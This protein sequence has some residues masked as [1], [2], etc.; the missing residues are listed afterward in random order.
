MKEPFRI[1]LILTGGQG[2]IGGME[3]IKNIIL[4]LASL[5]TEVRA[6]FEISLVTNSLTDSNFIEPFK[7]FV[8]KVHNI[9]TQNKPTLFKRIKRVI[10]T[11]FFKRPDYSVFDKFLR[12]NKFDF[13]YPYHS[14][15]CWKSL[16]NVAPWIPDFQ[17]K[18]L[19]QFFSEQ[20]I[21]DRDTMFADMAKHA[22]LVVISSRSAEADFK[23]FYPEAANKAKVLSFRTVSQ[24]GWYEE[25]PEALQQKYSLPDKFF[26]LC[27]QFWQHKNHLTV[28]RAMQ[29]LLEK[30]VKP[31]VVCTGH[32]YDY[33]Q[34]NYSDTIL[35]TIHMSGLAG[36]I[37]LLGLIPKSD[38][39]Q[40]L[41]RSI[42]L[43]QP[44]LFEGWSTVI[45]EARCMGK[46]MI[47]SDFS[48][49]LEQN[50]PNSRF[51]ERL[52]PES[53]AAIMADCWQKLS[54]GPVRELESKARETNKKDVQDFAYE[55]LD[56]ARSQADN[57]P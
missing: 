22:P 52:S 30:G 17:H 3:Y 18:Y 29:I 16:K 20:E 54:P 8:K 40:L 32:I 43:I 7:P 41:R 13:I 9:D 34:P 39:I 25:E 11:R 35:R 31:V 45:E 15:H 47:L 56:I 5:P 49:H 27:N 12:R 10:K 53:L 33:R 44:S 19:P 55:F 23:R 28:F 51:F 14:P 38:Q 42:A 24:P 4:A 1:A 26:I 2:W 36:Q 46:P 37:Y 48:V 6:T 50:P 21:K 57:A